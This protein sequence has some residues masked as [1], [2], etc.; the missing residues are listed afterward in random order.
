MD[1]TVINI[2]N[3]DAMIDLAPCIGIYQEA[4]FFNGYSIEKEFD[5]IKET[6]PDSKIYFDPDETLEKQI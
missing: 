6:R 5:L 1:P 2:Q 3:H 4:S